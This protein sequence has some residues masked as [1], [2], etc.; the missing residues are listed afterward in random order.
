MCHSAQLC[1]GP[2]LGPAPAWGC[3]DVPSNLYFVPPLVPRQLASTYRQMQVWQLCKNIVVLDVPVLKPRLIISCWFRCLVS[4]PLQDLHQ[5]W[6]CAVP[7]GRPRGAWHA[8]RPRGSFSARPA[9]YREG[10]RLSYV[11]FESSYFDWLR[12]SGTGD[13]T[14]T[15]TSQVMIAATGGR[16]E[17]QT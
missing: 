6:K 13:V 12:L 8:T 4:E 14:L 15:V 5:K 7:R 17:A 1:I 10:S 16:Q 3:R 11:E 2:I 9:H